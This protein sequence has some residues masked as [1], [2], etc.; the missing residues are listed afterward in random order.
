M[1][2]RATPVFIGLFFVSTLLLVCSLK[3]KNISITPKL[4]FYEDNE[5]MRAVAPHN[6]LS[7]RVTQTNF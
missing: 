2:E 1:T 3:A 7:G 6:P 4:K 5:Q